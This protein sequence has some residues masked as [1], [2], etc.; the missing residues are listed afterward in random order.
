MDDIRGRKRGGRWFC[1]GG[2]IAMPHS[3]SLCCAAADARC[4]ACKPCTTVTRSS[5]L[6][7]GLARARVARAKSANRVDTVNVTQAGT[8]LE[9][10]KKK[11]EGTHD[12]QPRRL[13]GVDLIFRFTL[14]SCFKSNS[15]HSAPIA[16]KP[17]QRNTIN[18]TESGILGLVACPVVQCSIR[19]LCSSFSRT[20]QINARQ[21]L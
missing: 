6:A 13:A 15:I 2:W 16:R 19:Q 21:L 10:Q 3:V 4:T 1:V 5:R 12:R 18:G 9:N 7:G 11:I 8:R 17:G 20:T 14:D